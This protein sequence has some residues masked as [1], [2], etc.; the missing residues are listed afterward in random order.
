MSLHYR[1]EAGDLLLQQKL[2]VPSASSG[3][4]KD[5]A[6]SNGSALPVKAP[7]AIVTGTGGYQS[8]LLIQLSH[9]TYLVRVSYF[10]GVI[11]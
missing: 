3:T 9:K 8:F 5:S 11:V 2:S 4:S 10:R 7:T 1:S 6:G